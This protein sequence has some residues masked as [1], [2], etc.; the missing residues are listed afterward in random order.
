M[1]QELQSLS[2]SVS[3]MRSIRGMT[4]IKERRR[5][6]NQPA[7]EHSPEDEAND[8]SGMFEHSFYQYKP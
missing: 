7:L 5:L 1:L 8:T 4:I 6:Q 3:P 2:P